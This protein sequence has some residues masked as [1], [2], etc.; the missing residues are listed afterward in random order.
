M[1]M[2]GRHFLW[3][4]QDSP[5]TLTRKASKKLF[6]VFEELGWP[7]RCFFASYC[8]G[9]KFTCSTVKSICTLQW[10]G[11]VFFI[12]KKNISHRRLPY[13]HCLRTTFRLHICSRKQLPSLPHSRNASRS[14]NVFPRVVWQVYFSVGSRCI[15]RR[16]AKVLLITE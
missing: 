9:R 3:L 14:R 7:L 13:F 15:P 12:K 4:F 11:N 5:S 10:R 8:S 16:K 1:L 2:R 6:E